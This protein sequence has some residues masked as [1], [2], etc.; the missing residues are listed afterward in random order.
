MER[1]AGPPRLTVQHRA[2][3]VHGML[4][5]PNNGDYR[6]IHLDNRPGGQA[7]AA[8]RE[9]RSGVVG[10]D[11]WLQESIAAFWKISSLA[12]MA[13]LVEQLGGAHLVFVFGAGLGDLCLG[14]VQ[15]RL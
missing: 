15:L 9:L 3:F 7:V 10:P 8:E 4:T 2:D 6:R 1:D 13:L 12:Q 5:L 14:Q 11:S